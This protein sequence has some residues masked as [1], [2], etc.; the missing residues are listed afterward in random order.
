MGC[1]T[2]SVP[3]GPTPFRDVLA[4][5]LREAVP[6]E[7]VLVHCV[8]GQ[9]NT[10][11]VEMAAEIE[12]GTENG[13]M[14]ATSVLHVARDLLRRQGPRE[15]APHGL[16]AEEVDACLPVVAAMLDRESKADYD[17]LPGGPGRVAMAPLVKSGNPR[18]RGYTEHLMSTV[19]RVLEAEGRRQGR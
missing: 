7:R 13:R 15:G 5:L 17:V 2:D 19:R 14:Y 10:T 9:H 6:A 1:K 8:C 12:A 3:S 16:S 4:R 11:A 18:G